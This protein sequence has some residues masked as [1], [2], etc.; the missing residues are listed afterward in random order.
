MAGAR[1]PLGITA[2]SFASLSLDP[3]LVLWSP[4]RASRRFEAFASAA[5]FAIHVLG[6]GQQALAAHFARQGHDF[7]L[8][9][10]MTSAQGVPILPGC[11][12]VFECTHEAL[13][14]GGDHAIVVGRVRTVHHRP[15]APLAFHAGQFADVTPKRD[16][17]QTGPQTRPGTRA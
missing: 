13:H 7:D 17:P 2:N 5:H 14:A 4:A 6:A 12:A 1:G 8:P 16:S 10:L 9:G 11:L 15:G 3:P